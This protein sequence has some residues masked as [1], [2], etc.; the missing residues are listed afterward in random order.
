MAGQSAGGGGPAD[1][2]VATTSA[3]EAPAERLVIL[4]KIG[5]AFGVQGWVKV[6]SFT[7]PPEN[8]LDYGV[9]QVG[10]AGRWQPVEV[11]DGRV[12][13]KGVLAKLAGIDSPEEARIQAGAEIAVPRS[14]LPPPARG[15]Y[16]WSDLEGLEAVTREGELLGRVDHFR[17]TPAG[18]MVVVRGARE[19]WIP[20]VSDRIV[21]VDLE[22]GRI[23]FDW[24][25]DY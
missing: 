11:E 6:S 15:E 3:K 22:A 17:G 18:N 7:E 10:R 20:F 21:S 5:G 19:H 23:V 4:G 16:Y 25:L 2:A 9:W 8:I 24:G 14:E 1:P 12:T 13:G